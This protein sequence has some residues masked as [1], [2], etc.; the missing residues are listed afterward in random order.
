MFP[1]SFDESKRVNQLNLVVIPVMDDQ[2]R[3][4]TGEITKG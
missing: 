1:G 4:R 2:V 3:P